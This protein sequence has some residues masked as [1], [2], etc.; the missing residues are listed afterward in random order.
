MLSRGVNHATWEVLEWPQSSIRESASLEIEVHNERSRTWER[1]GE[2]QGLCFSFHALT[3]NT[4]YK[5]RGRVRMLYSGRLSAYSKD[6]VFKTLPLHPMARVLSDSESLAE[7]TES[8]RIRIDELAV[9]TALKDAGVKHYNIMLLGRL[10]GGKS[11]FLN[12]CA[13]ALSMKYS[14]RVITAN[15]V[16]AAVTKAIAK[17]DLNHNGTIRMWDTFG[18]TSDENSWGCLERVI[19]G[20]ALEDLANNDS[21]SN[22]VNAPKPSVNEQVHAVAIVQNI[23]NVPNASEMQSLRKFYDRLVGK[24]V[25]P[26]VILC[27]VDTLVDNEAERTDAI[28][29]NA[30]VESCVFQFEKLTGIERRFVFPMINYK[31]PPAKLDVAIHMLAL[32]ALERCVDHSKTRIS[33]ELN[34][35]LVVALHDSSHVLFHLDAIP[36]ETLPDLCRRIAVGL[37]H[38]SVVFDFVRANGTLAPSNAQGKKPLPLHF[39]AGSVL[40]NSSS[41]PR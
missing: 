5:S 24:D 40:L 2:S 35:K 20:F 37:G 17:V 33:R 29:S 19:D 31:G 26:I 18:W 21:N 7:K 8:L 4:V 6:C 10:G 36:R 23:M 15:H 9:E 27:K 3:A 30:A 13:T 1:I 32:S 11:S 41:R 38:R 39:A 16:F 22:F 25:Q 14:N 12:T 34:G 28:Y